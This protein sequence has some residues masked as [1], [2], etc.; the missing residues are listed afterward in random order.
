M[1]VN[2]LCLRHGGTHLTLDLVKR[3]ARERVVDVLKQPDNYSEQILPS[4]KMIIS[5]RDPR[6]LIVSKLRHDLKRF[7]TKKKK[8]PY[9]RRH[10]VSAELLA[11]IRGDCGAE[12]MKRSR[13]KL[14]HFMM[15]ADVTRMGNYRDSR[16]PQ[17]VFFIKYLLEVAQKWSRIDGFMLP[18]EAIS[19]PS[20]GELLSDA[21]AEYLGGN[22][23]AAQYRKIYGMGL[24]FNKQNSDWREWFGDAANLTF[25]QF[26]GN[27]LVKMLGYG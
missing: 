20:K 4:D 6:N 21:L 22:G 3:L 18:F 14:V 24:T 5:W 8:T 26:G 27:R 15:V 19:D 11:A 23:G 1:A 16:F 25:E 9:L 10:G 2:V 17:R 12:Q 13:D 7:E